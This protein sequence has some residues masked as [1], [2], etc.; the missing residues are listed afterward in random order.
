[1][2]KLDYPLHTDRLELR[3]FSVDDLEDAYVYMSDPAV[4]RY[5]YWQVRDRD[6]V[7]AFL[8]DRALQGALEREGDRLTLALVLPLTGQV[9]GEVMLSWTSRENRQGEIGFVLNPAF[10]GNGYARE[11]ALV[12]LALGFDK[13]GLHRI[14]GRCDALNVTSAGL[15]ERLGMRREAHFIHDE[16]FKGEWGDVLV[17]AMLEDEWKKLDP[18]GE[19]PHLRG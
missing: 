11:A 19:R 6:E 17:Y 3:P 9:V 14:V 1:V 5:L 2:L 8:T 18:S 7:R 13:L 15:M 10:Q 4:V 16:I 12:V